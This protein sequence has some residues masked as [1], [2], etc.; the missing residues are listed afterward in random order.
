MKR[1]RLLT[2]RD[3]ARE[4]GVSTA[5][6]SR[7]LNHDPRVRPETVKKVLSVVESFQYS[8]HHVARSLKTGRTNTIGVLAPEFANEFF[9]ELAESMEQELRKEGYSLLI[10]SSHESVEEEKKRIR[11]FIERSVDGL[12]II[13]S[14]DRG[15]HYVEAQKAGIPIVLVD[16]ATSGVSC[17]AVLVDNVGGAYAAVTALIHEGFR[18]IAFIGGDLHILTSKERFEGY[19]RAL[20]DAGLSVDSDLIRLGDLH[21]ESGYALMKELIEGPDPPDAFFIVNL[22]MHVGATNY[23]VSLPPE[24]TREVVIASFDEMV[25]SPLL[26]FCRYAVAQPIDELGRTAVRLLLDRLKRKESS[27]PRIVRLPTSLVRH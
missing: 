6:V 16:R 4:A 18:R 21:I 12:V 11:M 5:T 2:I 9:M 24:K 3:I 26:R 10:S 14:S 27:S 13:P 23:L 15:E 25:Y 20:K 8:I 1:R 22:F 19:T 7:V 17:D